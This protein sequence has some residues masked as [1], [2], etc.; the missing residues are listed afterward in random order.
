MDIDVAG[1]LRIVVLSS[2]GVSFIEWLV[3]DRKENLVNVWP[4]AL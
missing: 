3:L 1:I 2:E 4:I